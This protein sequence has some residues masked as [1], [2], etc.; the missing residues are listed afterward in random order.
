MPESRN[1]APKDGRH[2]E[3]QNVR[4]DAERFAKQL[5]LRNRTF[6]NYAQDVL[7]ELAEGDVALKA[8]PQPALG[9][10]QSPR[11]RTPPNLGALKVASSMSVVMSLGISDQTS[12]M[13]SGTQIGAMLTKFPGSPIPKSISF[14][15]GSGD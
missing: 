6:R 8:R 5:T 15:Y 9:S 10:F 14:A 12:S 1:V 3:M 13:T 7:W 2:K 11:V 4:H